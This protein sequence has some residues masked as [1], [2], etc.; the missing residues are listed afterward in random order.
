MH[1]EIDS[2]YI[3]FGTRQSVHNVTHERLY[4]QLDQNQFANIVTH[5]I[6]RLSEI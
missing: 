1:D 4:E 6:I 5:K 2:N 3:V